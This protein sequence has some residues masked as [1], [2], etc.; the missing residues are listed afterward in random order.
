M[1]CKNLKAPQP[2]TLESLPSNVKMPQGLSLDSVKGMASGKGLSDAMNNA[3]GMISSNLTGLKD[4]LS[5]DAIASKIGETISG[6]ADGIAS[7]VTG[8]ISSITSIGA[9]IKSFDPS[10][11]AG[12]IKSKLQGQLSGSADFASLAASAKSGK[13]AGSYVS[14]AGEFNK[15]ISDRAKGQLA[16]QSGKDKRRMVSDKQ[17]R[18]SKTDEITENVKNETYNDAV[19]QSNS[20]GKKQ[21]AQDDLTSHSVE[22]QS[23]S[24]PKGCGEFMLWW[25]RQSQLP[26]SSLL[27]GS[28]VS[29]LYISAFQ[30]TGSFFGSYTDDIV[31]VLNIIDAVN[32]DYVSGLS[33]R[34]YF[35]TFFNENPCGVKWDTVGEIDGEK[36]PGTGS[37]WKDLQDRNILGFLRFHQPNLF[38]SQNPRKAKS[39][40]WDGPNF[41]YRTWVEAYNTFFK[42]FEWNNV[43]IRNIKDVVSS[44]SNHNMCHRPEAH[45]WVDDSPSVFGDA[46]KARDN[47]LKVLE[48]A[49]DTLFETLRSNKNTH[50]RAAINSGNTEIAEQIGSIIDD[51]SKVINYKLIPKMIAKSTDIET[52]WTVATVDW[53]SPEVT[54]IEPLIASQAGKGIWL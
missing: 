34:Y 25:T 31:D 51:N 1:S 45:L 3:Q 11:A 48:K 44:R 29:Y 24:N 35:R 26:V 43:Y 54:K 49:E 33:A 52:V 32:D 17:F 4:K 53:S 42:K 38:L 47:F 2:P 27:A 23:R 40:L 15:N 30:K 12:G 21:S 10:S 18:D 46:T 9:R 5:P 39:A 13:C 14:E 16:N 37:I 20:S 28:A 19:D 41:S 22:S 8:A 50:Q 7:K 36:I 6:I